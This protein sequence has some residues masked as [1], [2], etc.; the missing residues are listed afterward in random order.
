[1]KPDN[2]NTQM[3]QQNITNE[4]AAASLGYS[5]YL[6]QQMLMMQNP[7][8]EA[9]VEPQEAP[10][11]ENGQDMGDSDNMDIEAQDKEDKGDKKLDNSEEKMDGKMEILRTE[12]KDTIK[13]EIDSIK[14]MIK[15]ALSEEKDNGE[16]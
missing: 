15:D 8:Q 9:P 2:I 14:Q 6:L 5:N 13:V 4:E 10:Q 7:Q 11:Q 1:M 16:N 3:Q 12:L